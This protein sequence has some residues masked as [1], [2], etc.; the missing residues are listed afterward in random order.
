MLESNDVVVSALREAGAR[1][2]SRGAGTIVLDV[3]IA[4]NDNLV[5]RGLRIAAEH[6]NVFLR[7]L[8]PPGAVT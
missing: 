8:L 4:T 7:R 1:E 6:V 2:V 3:P 5:R